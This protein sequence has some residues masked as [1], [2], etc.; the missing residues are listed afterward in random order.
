MQNLGQGRHWVLGLAHRREIK[1]RNAVA[2]TITAESGNKSIY[3]INIVSV[4]LF[5]INGDFE[6]HSKFRLFQQFF[7]ALW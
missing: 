5:M 4:N 1:G 3:H 7:E 6:L 2:A